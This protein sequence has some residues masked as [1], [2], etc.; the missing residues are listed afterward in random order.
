MKSNK[1]SS[2]ED[3]L[4]VLHTTVTSLFQKKADR[5]LE[6]LESG[7]KDGEDEDAMF[8]ID[9]RDLNAMAK[10]VTAN[11]I[12]PL[13]AKEQAT[14]DLAK[15]LKLLKAKHGGKVISFTDKTAVEG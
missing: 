13:E 10:W 5:M 15:S 6:L 4:G 2:T 11:E 1:H 14:S 7:G 8:V 9:T 3:S 12:G